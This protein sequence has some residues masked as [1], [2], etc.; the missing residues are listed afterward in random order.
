MQSLEIS[1]NRN[2]FQ[3]ACGRAFNFPYQFTFPSLSDT[4]TF[5]YWSQHPPPEHPGHFFH[6]YGHDMRRTSVS[7]YFRIVVVWFGLALVPVLPYIYRVMVAA[8]TGV[9]VHV[10]A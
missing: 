4:K 1:F 9:F 7:C 5:G 10:A 8:T 2:L 6:A 3:M